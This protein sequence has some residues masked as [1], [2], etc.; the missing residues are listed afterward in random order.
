M[1]KALRSLVL[2]ASGALVLAATACSSPDK[3]PDKSPEE[4]AAAIAPLP[5]SEPTAAPIIEAPQAL[6]KND[7]K[8]LWGAS[9]T[10]R[11]H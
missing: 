10:G 8:G 6:T 7:S 5:I 3:S 4:T 11:S 2:L 9:S 1:S